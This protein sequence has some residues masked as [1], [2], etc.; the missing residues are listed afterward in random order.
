MAV[1]YAWRLDANKFA[2]ILGPNNEE[3]YLT[4]SPLVGDELS[5]VANTANERFGEEGSLGITGYNKAYN[6]MLEKIKDTWPDLQYADI[7][8]ADVYYNVDSMICAD[9]KGVGIRGVKYLG[10]CP[11]NEWDPNKPSWYTDIEQYDCINIQGKFSVYGIYMEDQEINE[12]TTPENIFAVY[13]GANGAAADGG[14]STLT[15]TQRVDNIIDS[16]NDIERRIGDLEGQMK[17]IQDILGYYGDISGWTTRIAENT[18]NIYKLSGMTVNQTSV[19]LGNLQNQ[20]NDIN[21]AVEAIRNGDAGTGPNIGTG[22]ASFS[23]YDGAEV[24]LVGTD[25]SKLYEL[26]NGSIK[27]TYSNIDGIKAPAFYQEGEEL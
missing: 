5:V 11:V 6:A 15:L 21:I 8:S 3:G 9:L 24:R 16:L 17:S 2:Y 4:E 22:G 23:A 18:E 27:A 19:N 12:T 1:T 20:I 10:V 25:G 14:D 13:N 7:L 26:T